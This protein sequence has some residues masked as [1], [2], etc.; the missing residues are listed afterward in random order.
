LDPRSDYPV[1]I[2]QPTFTTSPASLDMGQEFTLTLS[3]TGGA[4]PLSYSYSG[5]PPSCSSINS[6][7]LHCTPSTGRR[8][9]YPSDCIRPGWQ[10][11]DLLVEPHRAASTGHWS[12][13]KPRVPAI[14]RCDLRV[15]FR[16]RSGY[17][18]IERREATIKVSSSQDRVFFL[19]T[20][21]Q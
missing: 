7:V 10:D 20:D 1:S 2:K 3:T 5:L 11:C 13:V 18:A 12:N 14:R 6:P 16:Y 17:G 9:S 21:Q 15:H 4:A 8:L 19:K